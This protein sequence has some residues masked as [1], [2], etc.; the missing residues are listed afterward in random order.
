MH[1]QGTKP[2][3]PAATAYSAVRATLPCGGN[4][5]FPDIPHDHFRVADPAQNLAFRIQEPVSHSLYSSMV[6]WVFG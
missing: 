4:A 5:L 1:L 3:T 2:W 6:T